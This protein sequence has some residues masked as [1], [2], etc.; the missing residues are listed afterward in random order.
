MPGWRTSLTGGTL[1]G[2]NSAIG[3]LPRREVRL[4]QRQ[5]VRVVPVDNR[6]AGGLPNAGM[7]QDVLER[8][9]DRAQP[10]RLTDPVRMQRDAHHPAVLSALSI[11][12]VEMILD[13][14]REVVRLLAAPVQNDIVEIDRIG[15]R[16][17]LPGFDLQRK[18]LVIVI[19]RSEEHT[20]ELQ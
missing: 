13:L 15:D 1:A 8:G 17:Q 20:P 14:P 9:A 2:M 5:I 18:R 4:Q 7:R 3:C 19:K 10:M 11:N 12:G 6:F 16:K